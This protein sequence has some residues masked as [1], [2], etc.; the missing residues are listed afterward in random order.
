MGEF[1]RLPLFVF[2]AVFAT[3]AQGG[4]NC[5]CWTP[6]AQQVAA[7]EAAIASRSLPLGSLNRYV[8][9]YTGT[10]SHDHRLIRGKLVPAS[11]N[12]V[13]GIHIVQGRMPLL[14]GDGCV[15]TILPGGRTWAYLKCARPGTWTPSDAQIA[16]LERLLRLPVKP[17]GVF[18][19]SGPPFPDA[20]DWALSRAL[21][22]YARHYAG[23][24]EGDRQLIV[25]KFVTAD[26]DWET[27]GIY[28]GSE[29]ELPL[30]ADGG[31]SVITVRHDPSTG[32]IRSWCNGTR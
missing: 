8:R 29:A 19:P 15:T 14:Q 2:A 27:A 6:D 11:S 26:A 3:A 20:P 5:R 16:E 25:G 32:E 10:I 9:Y 23:V 7:V 12:D 13:P 4:D 22:D 31:C 21:S 30:I 17:S 1:M 24:T 18:P 28:I